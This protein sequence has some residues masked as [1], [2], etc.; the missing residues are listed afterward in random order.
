[1]S[2]VVVVVV[3][4]AVEVVRLGGTPGEPGAQSMQL[5]PDEH[6]SHSLPGPRRR[7]VQPHTPE[8]RAQCSFPQFWWHT[9]CFLVLEM[10]LT[11]PL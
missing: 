1:M 10:N 7:V 8:Q 3:V 4:V 5:I 9:A 2:G 11:K 6:T